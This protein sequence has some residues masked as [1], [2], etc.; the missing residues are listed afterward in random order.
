M[1]GYF[2]D[3]SEKTA[4]LIVEDTATDRVILQRILQREGYTV[5]IAETGPAA[6]EAAQ[7]LL[8]LLIFLDYHLPGMD[9]FAVMEALQQRAE[10]QGIPVVFLTTSD[11]VSTKIRALEAGAAD[12][13]PKPVH[14]AEVRARTRNLLRWHVAERQLVRAQADRLQ[15]LHLAQSQM[16]TLPQDLPDAH[17]G[18]HYYSVHEAGGDIYDVFHPSP[19]VS[20]YFL[21]DVSG[22]DIGTAFITASVKALLRQN[23]TPF[24]PPLGSMQL[25]NRVMAQTLPPGRYLT[26]V[27]V[28]LN[29]TRRQLIVVS[30]GHPPAVYQ[31]AGAPA[32]LL[33]LQGDLLGIFSDAIFGTTMLRPAAGDRIFL[34]T[35]GI[36]EST[37]DAPWTASLDRLLS[38]AEATRGLPID[39]APRALALALGDS[40]QRTDDVVVLGFEI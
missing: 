16:L 12:Y 23:C 10:T 33:D 24:H 14:A 25:I 17:F 34:Y 15:Q 3:A 31:P 19:E 18:V 5:A 7:R 1:M 9:G 36:L 2:G 39:E 27:Y 26:A 13:L 6:V 8:P 20:A 30:M 38:C 21:G 40:P 4:I 22:H 28:H 32:R 11:D 29:R 35:D 37:S